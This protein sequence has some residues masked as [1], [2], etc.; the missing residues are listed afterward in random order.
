M[1]AGRGPTSEAVGRREMEDESLTQ[2]RSH[3]DG[4]PG[5]D[6]GEF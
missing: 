5:T 1:V 6:S 2:S 3:R 4:E